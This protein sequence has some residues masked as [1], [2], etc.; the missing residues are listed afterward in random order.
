M[1][2]ILY[3]CVLVLCGALILVIM[4]YSLENDTVPDNN[5]TLAL[6]CGV[7]LVITFLVPFL[8]QTK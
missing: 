5:F 3:D 4:V 7:L 1:M 2:D 8:M 6:V